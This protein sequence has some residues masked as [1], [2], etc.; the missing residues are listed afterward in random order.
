MANKADPQTCAL[1]STSRA[2]HEAGAVTI[3]VVKN[4]AMF[5]A[6]RV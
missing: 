4:D 1:A 2:I 3:L 5:H 6:K